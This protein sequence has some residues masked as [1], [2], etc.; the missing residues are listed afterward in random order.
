MRYSKEEDYAFNKS[1]GISEFFRPII[2]MA[3]IADFMKLSYNTVRTNSKHDMLAWG[4]AWYTGKRLTTTPY[5]LNVYYHM[6]SVVCWE[7]RK[8][9]NNFH[10]SYF[11]HNKIISKMEKDN[12]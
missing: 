10:P 7:H 9:C 1:G 3:N 4:L 2:G 12:E 8:K 5:L 11:T 6:K